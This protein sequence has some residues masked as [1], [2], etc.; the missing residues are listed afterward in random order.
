MD[1]AKSLA[2][3]IASWARKGAELGVDC[4]RMCNE[5]AF[6]PGSVAQSEPHNVSAAADCL[7]FEGKF[8]CH[9]NDSEDAGYPCAGFLYAKAF[10]AHQEKKLE[11]REKSGL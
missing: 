4:G 7:A 1:T 5:C 3:L 6:R 8:N 10:Q 11:E 9:K 2:E